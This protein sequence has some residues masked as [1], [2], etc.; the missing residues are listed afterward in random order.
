MHFGKP[1]PLLRIFD[2]AKAR[3]FYLGFLGFTLDWEHRF[4]D[5]LPLY[6]QV[7]KGDCVLH[8]SEHH[9]DCSPGAAVRIAMTGIDAFQQQLL[10]A[11][12]KYARPGVE[13]TPWG[14]RDMQIT[15]PFGN[16][17]IFT[18]NG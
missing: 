11:Q 8:L 6:M 16:R 4:E 2:E 10:A 18:D 14:S 12:Y 17:L 15:D 3:E 7:S 9:G 1:T 13:A 5:G